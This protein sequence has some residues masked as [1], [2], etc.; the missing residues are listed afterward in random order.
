ML[1]FDKMGNY[2]K[3]FPLDVSK[4]GQLIHDEWIYSNEQKVKRLNIRNGTTT[5]VILPFPPMNSNIM[6]S[7]Q[8]LIRLYDKTLEVD[9]AKA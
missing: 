7:P 3:S 5:E 1:V 6:L 2:F 9:T 4:G 8:L